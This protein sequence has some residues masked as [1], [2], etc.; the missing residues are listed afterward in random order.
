MC[1]TGLELSTT[2]DAGALQPVP[3]LSIRGRTSTM[4][5]HVEHAK[6]PSQAPG[7][8]TCNV[9]A[10]YRMVNLASVLLAGTFKVY[11]VG[12][13]DFQQVCAYWGLNSDFF[14]VFVNKG[15]LNPA[16]PWFSTSS[17]TVRTGQNLDYTYFSALS[18]A[19]LCP[20]DVLVEVCNGDQTELNVC[21][22]VCCTL[23]HAINDSCGSAVAIV[24]LGAAAHRCML[25]VSCRNMSAGSCTPTTVCEPLMIAYGGPYHD[26]LQARPFQ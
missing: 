1:I 13:C 10:W 12:M 23:Q 20:W 21:N 3:G 8:Q 15:H 25:D 17:R 18:S 14:P 9:N 6:E 24:L 5:W 16:A 22:M 26:C 7:R 19:S 11:F 4:T 2:N